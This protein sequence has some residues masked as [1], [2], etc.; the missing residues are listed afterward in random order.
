MRSNIE[1]IIEEAAGLNL[2]KELKEFVAKFESKVLES[3]LDKL[4]EVAFNIIKFKLEHSDMKSHDLSKLFGKYA[5]LFNIINEDKREIGVVILKSKDLFWFMDEFVRL[6][7]VGVASQITLFNNERDLIRSKKTFDSIIIVDTIISDA[8]QIAY[9]DITV[10]YD[11]DIVYM[12][13]IWGL[14]DDNNQVVIMQ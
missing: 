7:S 1:V 9:S 5:S 4:Y 11:P 8:I 6:L 3:S 12:L 13:T 10:R 2:Y 14:V